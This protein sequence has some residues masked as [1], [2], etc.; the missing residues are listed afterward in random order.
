MEPAG[1]TLY[2]CRAA[3]DA[4]GKALALYKS[5][6]DTCSASK[7]MTAYS[8]VHTFLKLQLYTVVYIRIYSHT[9][10]MYI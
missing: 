2:L 3:I 10:N 7:V 1:L 5:C 8:R 6:A 9:Y 4:F